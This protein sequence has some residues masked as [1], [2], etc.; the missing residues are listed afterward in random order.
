MILFLL[1]G[2]QAES[3]ETRL[4]HYIKSCDTYKVGAAYRSEQTKLAKVIPWKVGD[5]LMPTLRYGLARYETSSGL[6][7]PE[8]MT[9]SGKVMDPFELIY[10]FK[11][12]NWEKKRQIY[13]AEVLSR[14]TIKESISDYFVWLNSE[15]VGFEYLRA[16]SVVSNHDYSLSETTMPE[17]GH[18]INIMNLRTE[19][20]LYKREYNLLKN[21]FQSCDI[22]HIQKPSDVLTVIPDK[23]TIIN[24]IQ[25]EMS[26]E[27]IIKECEAEKKAQNAY[28]NKQKF[29]WLPDLYY[30]YEFEVGSSPNPFREWGIGL[31]MKLPLSHFKETKVST[32]R[33]DMMMRR[34]VERI[35]AAQDTAVQ[36]ADDFHEVLSAR[37]QLEKFLEVLYNKSRMGG[38]IT[39]D[40]I[41]ALK[42]YK[43]INESITD[44]STAVYTAIF[45]R[46]LKGEAVDVKSEGIIEK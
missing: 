29:G 5:K 9:V 43:N 27:P 3:S 36:F 22:N 18:N 19:S 4:E 23:Q 45:N 46:Q 28:Y 38:H 13:Q 8:T 34:R 39:K 17:M 15:V 1:V 11:E 42:Q 2:F 32:A 33:C 26:N 37:K 6:T 20:S 35:M 25:K 12:A 31:E 10:S 40:Y 44:Y 7:N 41:D 30:R 14:D 16:A 24:L 21:R